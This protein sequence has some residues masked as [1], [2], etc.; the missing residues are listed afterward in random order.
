[1]L[2]EAFKYFWTKTPWWFK[3][4]MILIVTPM[5]AV[6]I[7]LWY[8]LFLPWQTNQIEATVLSYNEKRDLKYESL[9]EKQNLINLQTKESLE[10]LDRHQSLM[11]ELMTRKQ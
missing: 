5:A 7:I 1:M 6:S 11:F 3:A 10:R 2:K 4:P 9:V 8:S